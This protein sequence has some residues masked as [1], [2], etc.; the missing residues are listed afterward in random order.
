MVRTGTCIRQGLITS[1]CTTAVYVSF[2]ILTILTSIHSHHVTRLILVGQ[3]SACALVL[4][5]QQGFR[6]RP[7]RRALA[8]SSP[9]L[10]QPVPLE[11][12]HGLR[13]DVVLW[14]GHDGEHMLAAPALSEG[15]EAEARAEGDEG[16][17]RQRAQSGEV[18][19]DVLADV[20]RELPYTTTKSHRY[21]TNLKY[22]TR[23]SGF[24]RGLWKIMLGIL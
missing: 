1:L 4:S 2:F 12:G 17:L 6:L 8:H 20:G 22:S 14:V 16:V 21:S 18:G 11:E 24:V 5:A 23:L 9:V 15:V 3:D 10:V 7:S 19:R 13:R